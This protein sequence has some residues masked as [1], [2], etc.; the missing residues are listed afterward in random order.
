MPNFV[1]A[2][3]GRSFEQHPTVDMADVRKIGK[4]RNDN[5]RVAVHQA[6]LSDLTD[7]VKQPSSCEIYKTNLLL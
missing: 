6:F 1:H 5:L 7:S 3:S 4:L 2:I